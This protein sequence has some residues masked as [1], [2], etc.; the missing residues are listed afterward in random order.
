MMVVIFVD[1]IMMMENVVCEFE[2]VDLV[3]YLNQMGVKV[4]GVGIEMICIEGVKVMYG[5][6]YSIVQDWIEV[7]IF[8]V[9]VVVIQGNVLVEDVIVEYNKLLILKMCEMG[10]I[11]MEELVGIWVIGL[12]ILKLIFVK[13]MF[14]LG[15]LMDM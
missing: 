11:V 13:M 6:D 10:V 1:G 12:E 5:C 15:F 2:I 14:Y 9:V 4:I 8:M 7:G 3:N